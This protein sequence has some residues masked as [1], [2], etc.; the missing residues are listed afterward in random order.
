MFE[1]GSQGAFG[2]GFFY[3]HQ[4]ELCPQEPVLDLASCKQ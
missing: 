4:L 1:Y 3:V 2:E